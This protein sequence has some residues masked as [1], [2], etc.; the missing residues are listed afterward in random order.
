VSFT[1][2]VKKTGELFHATTD[3][4]TDKSIY[5][6]AHSPLEPAKIYAGHLFVDAR[7]GN[8]PW[9]EF[10]EAQWAVFRGDEL[11]E[12]YAELRLVPFRETGGR[13]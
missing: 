10:S 7:P 6:D 3:L 4:G 2:K 13:G 8:S 11:D 9:V 1:T 5:Q 12:F